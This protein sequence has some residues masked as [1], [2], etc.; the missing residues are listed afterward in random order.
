MKEIDLK[1]RGLRT[2][3]R[4]LVKNRGYKMRGMDV[5]RLN[6]D[7]FIVLSSYGMPSGKLRYHVQIKHYEYDNIFWK[8]MDM[9]SNMKESLSLRA[10]GVWIS[11]ML[12][13][14]TEDIEFTDDYGELAGRLL[15]ITD[16]VSRDF[17]DSHDI[18]EYVVSRDGDGVYLVLKCL[19]YIHMEKKEEAA[20]IA[21]ESLA[22]GYS[23]TFIIGNKGFME[24]ALEY[25]EQPDVK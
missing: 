15:D 16:R 11:P 7:M 1:E 6:D 19:A 3:M 4:S 18:D 8:I 12:R 20:R 17:M 9:E 10:C 24:W 23:G 21:R 14:E 25:L 5:F 2:A 22:S 13:L